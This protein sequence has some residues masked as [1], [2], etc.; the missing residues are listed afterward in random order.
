[1]RF[2]IEREA[3]KLGFNFDL[4]VIIAIM[5]KYA[6]YA[7]AIFLALRTLG[8]QV[9]MN[10]VLMPLIAYI[11]NMLGAAVILVLGSAIVEIIADVV[12]YRLRDA[13]DEKSDE[14]WPISISTPIAALVRYFLYAIVLITAFLQLGVRAEGLL[15][16]VLAACIVFLGAVAALVVFS[17]KD[18]A[19]NFTAGMYLK[20]GRL[21]DPGD[22]IE[23]EG[24]SGRVEKITAF[25]TVIRA[26]GRTYVV[27]NSKMAQGTFAV[28]K[29]KA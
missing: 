26:K 11:P 29:K 9:G 19:P 20:R 27:P 12:K 18:H 3:Q 25:A 14:S 24:I 2:G 17:L 8:V 4:V 13:I 21:L 28:R 16:F 23:M 6:V 22:K 7:V 15:A 1:M 10:T 5:L